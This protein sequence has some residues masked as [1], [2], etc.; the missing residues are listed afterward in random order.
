MK[1]AITEKDQI[2][3]DKKESTITILSGL[4]RFPDK[5]VHALLNKYIYNSDTDISTAAIRAAAS[6]ENLGAGITK[7]Y[8][9][10]CAE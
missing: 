7:L 2:A 1:A 9:P 10:L 6:E 5:E 4:K 8:L 3:P